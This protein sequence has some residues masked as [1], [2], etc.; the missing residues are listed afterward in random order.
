M[1]D[2][3]PASVPPA[4]VVAIAGDSGGKGLPSPAYTIVMP[5]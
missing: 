5:K 2:H 3:R 4:Q 1:L